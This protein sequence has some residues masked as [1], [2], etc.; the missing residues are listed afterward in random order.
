MHNYNMSNMSGMQKSAANKLLYKGN[1]IPMPVPQKENNIPMP[2]KGLIILQ[3][4]GAYTAYLAHYA[5]V[6]ALKL[7]TPHV[8]AANGKKG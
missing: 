8:V 1:N 2:M 4:L 5:N 6:H 7:A 3:T